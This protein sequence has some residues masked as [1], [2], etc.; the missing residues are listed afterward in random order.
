MSRRRFGIAICTPRCGKQ[1]NYITKTSSACPASEVKGTTGTRAS[2]TRKGLAVSEFHVCLDAVRAGSANGLKQ[3]R[4]WIVAHQA[5]KLVGIVSP[6][7]CGVHI[8][9]QYAVLPGITFMLVR[10]SQLGASWEG[11][12]C[13]GGHLRRSLSGGTATKQDL[14]P[15]RKKPPNVAFCNH[16]LGLQTLPR[17]CG[18]CLR[19][20]IACSVLVRSAALSFPASAVCM[21]FPLS[22]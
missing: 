3:S 13:V 11:A 17:N 6:S 20:S 8:S 19:S 7:C 10:A 21:S 18:S 4:F 12:A 2:Q 16:L 22:H 14:P 5:L 9:R 15:W 1:E